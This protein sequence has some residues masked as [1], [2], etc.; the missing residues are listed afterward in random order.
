[1]EMPMAEQKYLLVKGRS[2]V[3]N[4]VFSLLTAVLY[5]RLTRRRLLV[6]WSDPTYSNLGSNAVHQFF[7]SELFGPSDE[8]PSTDSVRPEIWRGHLHDSAKALQ[9]RRAPGLKGDP[10]VWKRFSVSLSQLD[11]PEEVLVMWTYFPLIDQ[12]RRHLH[13]EFSGLREL[14]TETILRR[15]VRESLELHPAIRERVD[16]IKRNWPDEPAIG[17]HIRST[18]K[19]T[20]IRAVRRK[21]DDLRAQHPGAPVFL[22]SDS[23]AVEDSFARIWPGLLTAPKWYPSGGRSLHQNVECP[24]RTINGIEALIDLYLL[25]A[26]G[27]LVVDTSSAFSRLACVLTD[28]DHSHICDLHRWRALPPQ[29]RQVLWLTHESV[30]WGPRRLLAS[31]RG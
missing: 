19:L 10:L 9:A 16:G 20:N 29:V 21:V 23:R 3:G 31:L 14:G 11:Y 27:Y 6:D 18:D 1:M 28:A 25:A 4:R 7:I 8:I 22:A 26:C 2:G 12:L 13:G 24:D 30:K 15:L 5:A 17:V